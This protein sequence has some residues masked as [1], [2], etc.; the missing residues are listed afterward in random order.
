M[1][2]AF[3]L[4]ADRG[5][6]ETSKSK[7]KK[8]GKTEK[9]HRTRFSFDVVLLKL[10]STCCFPQYL[11]N[12]DL[13]ML[14]IP[15]FPCMLT[16]VHQR[17]PRVS[18]QCYI[19]PTEKESISLVGHKK[20]RSLPHPQGA[21]FMPAAQATPMM[22][23]P[24]GQNVQFKVC[25]LPDQKQ[26]LNLWRHNPFD[27]C[28]A[29]LDLSGWWY[30]THRTQEFPANLPAASPEPPSN[31]DI[32]P[33]NSP[34]GAAVLDFGSFSRK[35]QVSKSIFSA[36]FPLARGKRTP[37]LNCAS[38]D[39]HS[40]TDALA[41]KHPHALAKPHLL[42]VAA[43]FGT[44][45]AGKKTPSGTRGLFPANNRA[46]KKTPSETR[47]LFPGDTKSWQKKIQR[48]QKNTQSKKKKKYALKCS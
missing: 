35:T 34:R 44:V 42:R 41:K 40:A 33:Q 23:P 24:W 26:K 37:F 17:P 13:A 1:R 18:W 21:R 46:G 11:C 38:A 39:L 27:F 43:F 22:S 4:H 8:R 29:M 20:K 48:W 5:S 32:C 31:L 3:S 14:D 30:T 47:V 25:A 2:D 36:F 16:G 12:I 6:P 45:R 19:F 28:V 15:H 9:C 10:A 7:I